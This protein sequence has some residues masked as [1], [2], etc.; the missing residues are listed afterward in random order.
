[1]KGIFRLCRREEDQRFLCREIRRGCKRGKK[2]QRMEARVYD[3]VNER[4]GEFG[5]RQRRGK[6]TRNFRNDISFKRFAYT[7]QYYIR[8]AAREVF[9]FKGRGARVFKSL[10]FGRWKCRERIGPTSSIFFKFFHLGT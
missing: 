4:S 6:R 10:N 2:K 3:I 5:K 9:V 1:V 8:K 7:R